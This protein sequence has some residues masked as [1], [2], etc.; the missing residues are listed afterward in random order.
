ME[1]YHVERRITEL[2]VLHY[3]QAAAMLSRAAR[4]A[5]PQ[6]IVI[7]GHADGIKQLLAD[8]PHDVRDSYAGWFAADPS[9][10]TPARAFELAAPVLARWVDERERQVVQQLT[11]AASGVRAAVG[12][13]PCLAAVNADAVDLLLMPDS[14]VVP[15]YHCERC[16]ALSITGNECCDWGAAARHVPD[17]LEEMALRAM[18][19]GADVV[20]ARVLP[21]VAAARL[22]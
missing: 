11:G 8:L 2:A 15:G 18:H 22:R 14:E 17:L 16:D 5:G 20:S 19:E 3:Q 6:P 10:L 9:A 13:E 4:A 7:G 1:S 21:V 12:L